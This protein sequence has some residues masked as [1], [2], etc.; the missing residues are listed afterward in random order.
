MKVNF[1]S[2]RSKDRTE[3]KVSGKGKKGGQQLECNSLLCEVE[4]SSGNKYLVRRFV[5]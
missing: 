3:N 2:N 5:F 4:C 1:Q